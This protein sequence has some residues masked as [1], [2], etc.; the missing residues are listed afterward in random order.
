MVIEEEEFGIISEWIDG[1]T[2]DKI[3]PRRIISVGEAMEWIE[4]LIEGIGW[5]HSLGIV[6]KD[7]KP[8]NIIISKTRGLV[9]IDLGISAFV[10]LHNEEQ[11]VLTTLFHRKGGSLLYKA[12]EMF[13]DKLHQNQREQVTTKS[14]VWSFASIVSEIF[15]GQPPTGFYEHVRV[16]KTYNKFYLYHISPN[17]TVLRF[18]LNSCLQIDYASRPNFQTI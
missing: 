13:E 9:I 5:L 4:Q 1:D 16:E 8:S 18:L 14:D 3:I 10:R 12:P 11:Q 15:K 2:L 7:L 6:H 17:I